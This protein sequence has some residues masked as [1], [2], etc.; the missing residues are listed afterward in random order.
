MD[1][2]S[3]KKSMIEEAIEKHGE[4]FPCSHI[5]KLE[6]CF[7]FYEDKVHFFFNKK[8]DTTSALEKIIN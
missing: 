3:I 4:I 5:E 6:D 7:V 8:N 2:D 1:Q